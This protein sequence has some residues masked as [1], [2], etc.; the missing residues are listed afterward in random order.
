MGRN[1]NTFVYYTC[2]IGH[3]NEQEHVHVLYMYEYIR[4]H[5]HL[6]ILIQ[7]WVYM[8]LWLKFPD[9]VY[10]FEISINLRWFSWRWVSI[11]IVSRR[12]VNVIKM[13]NISANWQKSWN[14]SK[15]SFFSLYRL[16]GFKKQG[17]NFSVPVSTSANPVGEHWF[18]ISL[19]CPWW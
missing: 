8:K 18:R 1:M 11:C 13:L 10:I 7:C 5:A 14:F 19:L 12:W 4:W 16:G 6:H 9:T 17:L 15:A 2:N 3:G